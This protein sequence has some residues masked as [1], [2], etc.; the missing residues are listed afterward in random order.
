HFMVGVAAASCFPD[1]VRAGAEGNPMYFILGGLFGLLPDTLDFKF[2]RFFY[3]HDIQVVPDPNRPD[4]QMIADAV[5]EAVRRAHETRKPVEIKLNT[6]RMGADEW[7]QYEVKFDVL[8]RCVTVTYGPIVDTSSNPLRRKRS[9]PGES[10]K[11][12]APLL[13]GVRLDYMATTTIDI[14]EGP[15]FR[16]VPL[17]DGRVT[18]IFIPWHRQW[19]HSFVTCLLMGLVGAVI[20]GPVAGLVILTAVLAHVLVDQLGFMGSSLLYPFLP[21]RN[22][23]LKLV[24]SSEGLANFGI[25]WFSALLVFWNLYEQAPRQLVNLSV[26]RLFLYGGVVPFAIGCFFRRLYRRPAVLKADAKGE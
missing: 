23:G 22:E 15:M 8:K 7:Q 14:F 12:S 6:V 10:A 1:A 19:S 24:H 5:A 17:K 16:V 9:R 13:C 4:P 2:C 11:A 21:R 20:L 18:P 3:R 25:V 26:V